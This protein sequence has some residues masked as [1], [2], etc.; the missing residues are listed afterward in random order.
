M[1]QVQIAKDK[2]IDRY[3]R[4]NHL[5]SIIDKSGDKISFKLNWAQKELYNN[6]WYCN[7]ILKARQLGVSTFITILFL[8]TCLFNSNISCGIIAHTRE[9]AEQIY[10]WIA[11]HDLVSLY[12]IFT[13]DTRY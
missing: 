5:Y 13:V 9:D 11:I 6:L 3:W 10:D 8:D 2:L 1:D 12:W 7:V 4:L